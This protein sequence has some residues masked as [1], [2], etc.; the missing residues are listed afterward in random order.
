KRKILGGY[1]QL[2]ILAGYKTGNPNSTNYY[3]QRLSAIHA[4][5]DIPKVSMFPSKRKI[6]R[7]GNPKFYDATTRRELSAIHAEKDIPKV[8]MFPS[9]RKILRYDQLKHIVATLRPEIQ[10]TL[11][12]TTR[13]ELSAIHAEKTYRKFP[14]SQVRGKSLGV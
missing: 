5:K 13:R 10:K 11:R 4:E 12:T 8:S 9:K 6:L 1:D 3:S 7:T 14:C 2:S